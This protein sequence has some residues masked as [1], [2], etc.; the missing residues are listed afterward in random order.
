MAEGYDPVRNTFVQSFG[1]TELDASLLLIGSTGFLPPDDPRLVG[2]VAAIEEDLL[3]DGFV[4][5]YR[6]QSNVDG[7]PPGEGAFLAC[8]FWLVTAYAA[9]G[10]RAEAVALFERLLALRND[11][12]LLAEEYDAGRKRQVG[13]FPQAFSHV[14][15]VA[16]AMTLHGRQDGECRAAVVRR[17]R[18]FGASRPA[19]PRLTRLTCR[20]PA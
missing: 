11:V 18:Q 19:A 14:A 20:A 13:N 7:L 12:G 17:D 9:Q 5:R 2:T 8:T 4:L 15:L 3:V 16:A 6:T 1:G 10:R